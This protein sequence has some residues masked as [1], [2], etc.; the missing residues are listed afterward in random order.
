[1]I[2][3]AI[4]TRSLAHVVSSSGG[5]WVGWPGAGVKA[6]HHHHHHQDHHHLLQEGEDVPEPQA[7]D[8][9]PTARLTADQVFCRSQRDFCLFQF[10]Q[11]IAFVNTYCTW[12]FF[13]HIPTSLHHKFRCFQYFSQ[14]MTGPSPTQAVASEITSFIPFSP[15]ANKWSKNDPQLVAS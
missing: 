7:G 13:N 10:H 1:M 2:L 11:K 6:S 5:R 15:V 12:Y 4:M 14:I 3:T 8:K 9:S